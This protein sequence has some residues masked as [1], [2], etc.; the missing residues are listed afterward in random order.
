MVSG[1]S[2]AVARRRLR[3]ALRRLREANDMTQ[4][5]V[6]DTLE[7]SLSK[8]QRIES[9]EVTVSS[10]DLRA[11]LGILGVADPGTVD[12]LARDAKASRQ[13]G[14]WDQPRFREHLTPALIK[15]LQ[16]ET[17]ASAIRVFSP[18]MI[19]GV[20]QSRRHAEAV[21]SF[22][23]NQSYGITDEQREARLEV[24]M[25]RHEQL[26]DRADR[27]AYLLVLDES[28]LHRKVGGA[29]VT[30]EQLQQLLRFIQEGKVS[31]RIVS[32]D[33]GAS[34]AMLGAFVLLD[35]DAAGDAVLYR[36]SFLRD[37]IVQ[38]EEPVSRH[39]EMFEAILQQTYSEDRSVRLVEARVAQLRADADH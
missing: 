19:P 36:E 11:I 38:V 3:L 18:T 7:W 13:R 6:A 2:P 9:G 34:A 39:R 5:Q 35:L 31:L 37:E 30:V 33:A 15:L 12:Q 16:F 8:V 14:W 25:R 23:N 32:F 28:V 17:Q 29:D 24:R 22:W 21:L 1:D 26:F 4:G 10:T 27:P 20:L